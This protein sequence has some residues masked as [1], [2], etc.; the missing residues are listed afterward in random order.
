V[1]RDT[2]EELFDRYGPGYRWFVTIGGLTASFTMVLTGT[3]VNVAIPDVMG[4]YGVGQDKAQFLSTAFIT[5]MTAS[6]LLNAWFVGKLGQRTAFIIVLSI[7]LLGGMI[8]GFSP[9]LD[10]IIFGRVMQGFAAGIVQPLVMVT[11]FQVFP[12]DRRGTAMAIYGMGLVL[13]LGFGPVVGGITIDTLGW[14]YIFFVPAPLVLIALTAGLFLMPSAKTQRDIGKFDWYGYLLLCVALFCLMTAI[15]H[16]Q[17]DGWTSDRSAIVMLIG[18]VATIGF[19]VSQLRPGSG[20]LDFTLFRNARFSAAILV[21]IVFGMGNF[22]STYA[23][24]VFGQIVQNYS[25]TVAGFLMLPASLFVVAALPITGRI[26]DRT[27]PQFPIMGGLLVFALGSFLL[28]QA[29]INTSFWTFAFYAVIARFGMSFITPALMATALS[30][31]PPDRLNQ[32]SGTINFFRQLGGAIG[33]NA[34]VV[35]LE[36]RTQFHSD[37]YAITQTASNNT[38]RELISNLEV[39]LTEAG[40]AAPQ[41]TPMALHHLGRVV[42][43]QA[44]T[45]GFQDG[46][47]VT[48]VVFL[49]ALIPAYILAR[50]KPS[51]DK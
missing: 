11:L 20:M 46:F 39:I 8:C 50:A 35:V 6:Q 29:D 43:A 15:G 32:G 19:V 42:E 21:A 48:S 23:I 22:A 31:L 18:L 33:I 27:P 38:T 49:L 47:I 40:V 37:A 10:L 13:A 34:L 51:R 1:A 3:I 41:V 24:P 5:T 4:A 16:G 44:N 26:T 30:S 17:R 9:N 45:M 36:L 12:S 14:R 7:F 25:A 2:V 28:S